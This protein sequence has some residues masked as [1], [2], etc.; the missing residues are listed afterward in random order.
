[1]LQTR[2]RVG[3]AASFPSTEPVSHLKK[4]LPHHEERNSLTHELVSFRTFRLEYK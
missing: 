4:G 3:E 2:Y 1:M